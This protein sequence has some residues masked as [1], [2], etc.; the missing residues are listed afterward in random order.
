MKL[1]LTKIS[2]NIGYSSVYMCRTSHVHRNDYV[3]GTTINETETQPNKMDSIQSEPNE[4][5]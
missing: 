4:M 3:F 2:D 1:K 5:E